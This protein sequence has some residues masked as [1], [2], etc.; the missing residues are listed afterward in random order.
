MNKSQLKELIREEIQNQ[1][2][3]QQI[4]DDKD[5]AEYKVTFH[6]DENTGTE[7]ETQIIK[8]KNSTSAIIKALE[9]DFFENVYDVSVERIS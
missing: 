9:N 4:E 8:S 6:A 1:L 5:V 3:E 7:K 2:N